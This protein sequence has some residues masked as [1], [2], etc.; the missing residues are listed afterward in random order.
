MGACSKVH[1]G[2]P[3]LLRRGQVVSVR[4]QRH[5]QRKDGA[6]LHV[7]VAAQC[8]DERLVVGCG[9]GAWGSR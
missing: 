5:C 4:A 3:Q 2:I 6:Q 8:S 7:V 1:A 9:R